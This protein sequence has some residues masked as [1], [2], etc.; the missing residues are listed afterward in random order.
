MTENMPDESDSNVLD[1]INEDRIEDAWKLIKDGEE[2]M[3]A[4][5]LVRAPTSE[6]APGCLG[7]KG[8]NITFLPP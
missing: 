2:W 4:R 1:A 5:D 8:E 7:D 3:D 6:V